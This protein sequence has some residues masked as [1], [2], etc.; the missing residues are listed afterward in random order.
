[1]IKMA[2]VP[3]ACAVLIITGSL[4]LLIGIGGFSFAGIAFETPGA[5]LLNIVIIAALI[6]A[7]PFLLGL[8]MQ[9]WFKK[10]SFLASLIAPWFLL[11]E[12]IY[13]MLNSGAVNVLALLIFAGVIAAL[14]VPSLV[15]RNRINP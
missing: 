10:F 3:L 14:S 11:A 9:K 12:A 7:L 8:K 15:I 2:W 4:V 1:M 5:P 6:C 13:L